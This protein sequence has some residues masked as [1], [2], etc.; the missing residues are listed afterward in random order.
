M[1]F[2]RVQLF[3]HLGLRSNARRDWG[4]SWDHIICEK[5]VYGFKLISFICS[6]IKQ[7]F[8]C[9]RYMN[10]FGVA[11]AVPTFFVWYRNREGERSA[12]GNVIPPNILFI[13][14]TANVLGLSPDQFPGWLS[15]YLQTLYSPSAWNY[16]LFLSVRLKFAPT[17]LLSL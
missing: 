8:L 14:L 9:V 15:M 17:I 16:P 12:C 4:W 7:L 5:R 2:C 1:T 3:I 13:Q 10:I 11:P 6:E